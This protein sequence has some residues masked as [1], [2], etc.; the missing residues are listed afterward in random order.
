MVRL[1]IDHVISPGG[2][3]LELRAPLGS[4]HLGVLARVG[5]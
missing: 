1:P 3:R 2:G 4:D 5:P